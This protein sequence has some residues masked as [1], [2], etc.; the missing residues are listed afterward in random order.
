MKMTR[1]QRLQLAATALGKRKADTV[2]TNGIIVNVHSKEH[3]RDKDIAITSGA[4]AYIGDCQQL[5]GK[6]TE[7]IDASGKFITPGLIDG[8][9]HV[10][11]T[12]L[13]VTEFAKAALKQGTTSIFMD[14]HEIANVF[15][16]KGV[17][18]MHEEG[19][20][21]PLRVF[22]TVP[23]CVPATDTLEDAGAELLPKDVEQALE[24]ENVTGLGEV[25]NFPGVVHGDEKMAQ[26]I[27]ATIQAGKTVTGHI[28][29]DD[30]KMLQA[31]VASGVTSC[32]ETVTR[33]QALEKLRLGMHV[34]IRE[35]SAWQD[36][37][38]LAPI[39]T[40]DH[41]P[42]DNLSLVTD[43]VYPQ[44]LTELGHLNYVIRKAVKEGVDP[45]TALQLATINAAKYFKCEDTLGSIAPGKWADLL[46]IDRL[47]EMKPSSVLVGG[48]MIY[49][50]GMYK[51]NFPVYTYPTEAKNSVHL[52]KELKAEDFHTK[53]LTQP[54][55]TV[56][57]IEVL[58]NNARTA[59][60]KAELTV[61]NSIIQS[62]IK[63]DIIH[64]ACIDRHHRSGQI[65]NAFVK[66]FQLQS[67]AVASTVAHDSHNLLVMGVNKED[68]AIA[69]NKI[70]ELGG[71]M[72]VVN[73]GKILAEVPL[74]I[75]G[76]MSDKPLEQ[77]GE[78]V[79]S[80]EQAWKK[81]GCKMN[82]PFM[83]FS[84]IALPVIPSIRIT[85]RG[86]ADVDAFEL[87]PLE[88]TE[89]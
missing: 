48:K 35:G 29:A 69:A 1:A 44:T 14:P 37:E 74:P 57:V 23:S 11:S 83:T 82:A 9:M 38:Q 33:E 50:Q 19:Q 58:E 65:S 89:S 56:N 72:I 21:L 13:S 43:D 79:K 20:K 22:T 63:E 42:T 17:R 61:R 34:M 3:I 41:V 25:M 8:H 68:M 59:K 15:G 26:E 7:V 60:A 85:N 46:F 62:N 76:L 47:A 27:E 81:L 24:W 28:P 2:I 75:A 12:M 32:H 67:G 87:M 51:V 88:I 55:V 78:Q 73:H 10:E 70:A 84:L 4:I 31:Y 80:L 5:I 40:K 30:P 54:K 36:V 64:L 49:D 71:G 86:I 39:I 52:K 77:V 6:E 66:G 18:W 53:T 45:I 16:L